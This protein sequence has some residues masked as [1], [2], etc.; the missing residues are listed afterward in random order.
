[1]KDIALHFKHEVYMNKDYEKFLQNNDAKDQSD[2]ENEQ[3]PDKKI[4]N[5]ESE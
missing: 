5:E 4:S 1:M 3:K 2:S